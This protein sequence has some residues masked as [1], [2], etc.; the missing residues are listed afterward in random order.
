M[1]E[2]WL[3]ICRS[4]AQKL[5]VYEEWNTSAITA[6]DEKYRCEHCWEKVSL[7]GPLSDVSRGLIEEKR[8][9]RRNW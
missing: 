7:V 2:R 3:E 9:L 4:C 1:S 6:F 8:I 5:D